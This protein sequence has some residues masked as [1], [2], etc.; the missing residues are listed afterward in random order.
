MRSPLNDVSFRAKV[1][2]R[3][4][5]D[6]KFKKKLL[7]DPKGALKEMG[8]DVPGEIHVKVIEDQASSYTFVLPA[9]PGTASQMSGEELVKIAGGAWTAYP[10][11]GQI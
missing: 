3:A 11:M 1:I 9:A 7:A 4:W 6:L 5:K 10:C 2:A 8:Y